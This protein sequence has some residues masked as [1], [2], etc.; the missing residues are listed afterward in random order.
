MKFLQLPFVR[1]AI[2]GAGAAAVVDIH[3][4]LSFKSIQ[5]AATYQWNTAVFRWVQGAVS[6]AIL[7][8]GLG[9]WL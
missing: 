8:A 9:A 2:S 1:G 5:E 7:G 4:F 6:G 3:A